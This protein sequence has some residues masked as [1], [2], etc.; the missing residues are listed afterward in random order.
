[1]KP[2]AQEHFSFQSN[3]SQSLQFTVQNSNTPEEFQKPSLKQSQDIFY[4]Y[5]RCLCH[6][7]VLANAIKTSA[8]LNLPLNTFPQF[9]EKPISLVSHC[10]ILFKRSHCKPERGITVHHSRKKKMVTN[11]KETKRRALL[12]QDHVHFREGSYFN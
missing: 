10:K 7:L 11:K 4:Y 2:P 6:H 9:Q 3:Y 8:Q 1:M 12:N 5:I